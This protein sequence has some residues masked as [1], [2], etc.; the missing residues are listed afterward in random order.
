[1]YSR[2]HHSSETMSPAPSS[3][4][5]LNT[6]GFTYRD[7]CSGNSFCKLALMTRA[8]RACSTDGMC[9]SAHTHACVIVRAHVQGDKRPTGGICFNC[10]LLYLFEKRSLR[11]S[12]RLAGQGGSRIPLPPHLHSLMLGFQAHPVPRFLHGCWDLDSDPHACAAV[13]LPTEPSPQ[14]SSPEFL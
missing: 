1:M 13:G 2:L 7:C 14:A 3:G 11:D 12:A 6:T 9:M 5:I 8:H 4:K 10:F